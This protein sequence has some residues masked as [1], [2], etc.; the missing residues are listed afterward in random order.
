MVVLAVSGSAASDSVAQSQDA[1]QQIARAC[2]PGTLAGK[3]EDAVCSCMVHPVP[4][5]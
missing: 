4:S 2:A 1:A 5:V 3:V